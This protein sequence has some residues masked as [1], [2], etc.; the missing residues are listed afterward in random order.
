MIALQILLALILDTLCGEPRRWHPLIGFGALVGRVEALLRCDGH[1]PRAQQLAGALGW[2]LLAALPALALWG[3]LAMFSGWL[4]V[5]AQVLVLYFT[6]GNRSLAEHAR[7]VAAPLLAGDL[8]AARYQVGMIVS[9]DTAALDEAGATRAAAESVLENGSDAVLAPLFWFALAGAPGAL[10]YRLANTLD[11]RWGYRSEKYLHFGRGAAR[12]DDLLNWLPARLCALSY[13]L[14]GNLRAALRC[15]REQ[16]PRAASPNAG[17]VMAAGA[18]ALGIR[19]GGP[20]RYHGREEWRPALG[21]GRDPEPRDIQRAVHLLWRAIALWL[22]VIALIELSQAFSTNLAPRLE[23]VMV[24]PAGPSAPGMALSEPP[25]MDSEPAP[26]AQRV[27]WVRR[28]PQG[29]P[30][31]PH[32]TTASSGTS[33]LDRYYRLLEKEIPWP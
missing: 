24:D 23:G 16:A 28:V 26:R 6:L 32:A 9:R 2:L 4:L 3:L 14:A 11:A 18:G 12:L 1:S 25:W 27:L 5:A 13:G 10:L 17:P 7:A 30:P 22:V 15:W 19:L 21:C 29:Y 33:L 31:S 20:A 8:T